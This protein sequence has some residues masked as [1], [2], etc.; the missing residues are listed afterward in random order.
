MR[1]RPLTA[2]DVWATTSI[3]TLMAKDLQPTSLDTP[4][5]DWAAW[6]I[7]SDATPTK[8]A[9]DGEEKLIGSVIEPIN[10]EIDTEISED[11]RRKPSMNSLTHMMVLENLEAEKKSLLKRMIVTLQTTQMEQMELMPLLQLQLP[12]FPHK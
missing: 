1:S 9:T 8:S 4:L 6:P 5:T 10:G 7:S 3:K 12:S 11:L 2:R